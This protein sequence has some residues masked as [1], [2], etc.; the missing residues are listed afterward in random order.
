ME[1]L[2]MIIVDDHKVY[3]STVKNILQSKYEFWIIEEVC[4]ADELMKLK[5]FQNADLILM[6]IMMPGMNG[7]ELTKKILWDYR[8]LKIV[9]NTMYI[10]NLYLTTILGAGFKGCIS[11]QYLLE[12]FEECLSKVLG[13]ELYYPKYLNLKVF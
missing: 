4:N 2:K 3:S 11:K 9:A 8:H 12:N 10:D 5:D 6:D 1:N 7:I 13:G